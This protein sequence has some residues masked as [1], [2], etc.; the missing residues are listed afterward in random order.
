MLLNQNFNLYLYT[1]TQFH[2]CQSKQQKVSFKNFSMTTSLS[3][4]RTQRNQSFN[5][6]II[7]LLMVS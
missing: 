1:M 3:C 2:F 7:N 6:T 5:K 4:Y